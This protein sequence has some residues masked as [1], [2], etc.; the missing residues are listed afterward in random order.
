M[1]DNA[2]GARR[3]G[4]KHQAH[5]QGTGSAKPMWGPEK[6]VDRI[7]A[8]S[9]SKRLS[10]ALAE[11]PYARLG[12]LSRTRSANR[13][14]PVVV[15]F[16]LLSLVTAASAVAVRLESVFP[17]GCCEWPR[18][19]PVREQSPETTNPMLVYRSVGKECVARESK[20]HVHAGSETSCRTS[21]PTFPVSMIR[22]ARTAHARQ[23]PDA[24]WP[25]V[26]HGPLSR[27]TGT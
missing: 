9:C 16:P 8:K 24:R 26:R 25:P 2:S 12:T 13:Y 7:V 20:H 22:P 23:T 14:H 21:K 3:Y 11:S 6:D 10:P 17:I 27:R 15:A 5:M 4:A 19:D 18:L 1:T